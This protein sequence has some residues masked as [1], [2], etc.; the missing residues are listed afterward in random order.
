MTVEQPKVVALSGGVGGA[1]LVVGLAKK[2]SRTG[3]W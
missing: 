3:S 2:S 1:K